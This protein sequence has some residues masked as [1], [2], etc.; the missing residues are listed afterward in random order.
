MV[1]RSTLYI[2]VAVTVLSARLSAQGAGVR[3]GG[4]PARGKVVVEHETGDVDLAASAPLVSIAGAVSDSGRGSALGDARIE[5][6]GVGRSFGTR[7]TSDGHF[8][9]GAVPAGRYTLRITRMGYEPFVLE[10]MPV[11]GKPGQS[12]LNVAMRPRTVALSEMVITPGEFG[13]LQRSLSETQSMPREALQS[14]PQLGEDIYRAVSRLPGVTTDDFSAKFGVRGASGNDLYVTLDGLELVEP[15]HMKDVGGAFSIIDIQTLGQASLNTGGFSAEYGD[16][17]AGVFTLTT[18]DPSTDGVHGSVAV[19]AMNARATLQGQ[20]AG[21]K[22]GWILSAR[23]GYLDFALK[24]TEMRDSIQPRYYDLFA[25]ATYAVAGGGRLA[26]HALRA[27]DTFRYLRRD[28]PN[29]SSGSG[30]SSAWA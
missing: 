1:G 5:L 14:V 11:V 12:A 20:F 28:Q 7:T 16:K 26:I 19:S 17:L 3:A 22:G 23:P 29:L 18:T 25:K 15:F 6:L 13:L 24:A 2:A 8:R 27:G 30:S 10:D 9:L 4:T 21:G